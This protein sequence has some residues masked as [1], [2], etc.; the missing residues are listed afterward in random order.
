MVHNAALV[1]LT[2]AF[3]AVLT[4][5]VAAWLVGLRGDPRWNGSVAGVVW[6]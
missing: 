2:V 3:G 6:D 1:A 5:D 4:F